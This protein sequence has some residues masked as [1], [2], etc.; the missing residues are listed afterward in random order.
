MENKDPQNLLDLAHGIALSNLGFNPEQ[1]LDYIRPVVHK[2]TILIDSQFAD[3][4]KIIEI[5]RTFCDE[6]PLIITQTNLEHLYNEA[7]AIGRGQTR[8]EIIDPRLLVADLEDFYDKGFDAGKEIPDWPEFSKHLR[9][10]KK[11][12]TIV[13]GIPGHGKSEFVDALM[14]HLA[15]KY[16][17]KFAVF[18]PENNPNVI[19]VE[20][21]LSKR[22]GKPFH[23]GPNQRMGKDEAGRELNFIGEHFRFI[24]PHEDFI[25]VE[26]ICALTLKAQ[27]DFGVDFM[28]I[29]PWN[30]VE[31]NRPSDK[32]ETEYIGET[33]MRLRRFAR[34]HDLAVFIVAHPAKVYRDK[35][36]KIPIPNPYSINGSAH[37]YNKADN[38]LCVFR[39]E[40]NSVD[41]HI[42]K[43]KFKMRGQVGSVRFRYDNITGRYFENQGV[44][45]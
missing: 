20:K 6:T 29:D 2:L 3:R 9:I 14:V 45:L 1:C 34:R 16:G 8:G 24:E 19:H 27:E 12:M 18:S 39:N 37:W 4:E 10:A 13:T 38:C 36:G 11:E 31:H 40:D 33:L 30:E 41:V 15:K 42:Q 22:V 32:S 5:A 28:L 26:N 17:F 44:V 35:E 21:I 7:K 23:D 25:T 43:V